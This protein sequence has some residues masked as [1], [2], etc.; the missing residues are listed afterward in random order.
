M[1]ASVPELMDIFKE[2]PETLEMYGAKPV[3]P[4]QVTVYSHADLVR[5][6]RFI[7]LYHQA[8][9]T[10]EESRVASPMSHD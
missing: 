8:G 4:S 3:I 2:S 6:V 9:T 1:Q 5:G 7:Q 10:M